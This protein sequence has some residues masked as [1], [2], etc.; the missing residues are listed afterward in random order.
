MM[1]FAYLIFFDSIPQQVTNFV[2]AS[3]TMKIT[4]AITVF[5]ANLAGL[6]AGFHPVSRP[7]VKKTAI[8]MG[9]LDNMFKP[10]HGHGTGEGH[11]DE[12]FQEEQAVLKDRK[13]RHLNKKDLKA[14]YRKESWI[15]TMLHTF[16]GHGSAENELDEMYKTQQQVLYE[17]REYGTNKAS[18]RSKYKDNKKDHHDEIKTIKFDPAALNKAEDDAMYID[19]N[20]QLFRMTWDKKSKP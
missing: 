7:A 18:L 15:E 5:L 12:M 20:A 8:Q 4:A 10:I 3:L 6:V 1:R 14:K 16:H 17:R 19:E 11:Y 2:L 9:L 13:R